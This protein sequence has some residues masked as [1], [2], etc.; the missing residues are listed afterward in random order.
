MKT[1][2]E[3]SPRSYPDGVDD[4]HPIGRILNRRE[5][6]MLLGGSGLAALSLPVIS[7]R[8]TV[9]AAGNIAH[10]LTLR[11][12]LP[13][14]IKAG[15][16]PTATV[17]STPMPTATGIATAVPTTT[18][19][20]MPMCVVRPA[21]TEGPFFL[22]DARLNRSDI[23]AN[24]ADAAS[25]P[26]VVSQ[27]ATL[28]LTFKVSH[29]SSGAC[30]AYQGV[31]VDV[32]HADAL[33]Q[34]S[35]ESS[36]GINTPGQNFLRGYQ[37][38]DASGQATFRTIYPGWYPSRT[39]HIHFKVRTSLS[40]NTNG[41]FTSQLFFSDDFTSQLYASNAPYNTH[42]VRDTLNSAD[43][44]YAQGGAQLLVPVAQTSS[45]YSGTFELGVSV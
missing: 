45:G 40:S 33:G 19:T 16:T 14:V 25:K 12:Y 42:A 11:A 1:S 10:D 29:V 23:R 9:S 43:T 31:Y 15:M 44:I 8:S 5:V 20:V 7:R 34:Y 13:L 41:V 4:D 22:D 32:W 2:E 26:G 17:T 30:V 38:T 18:P 37:V 27:G 6:L 24:T 21:L 39:V 28:D 3:V 35:G 36:M